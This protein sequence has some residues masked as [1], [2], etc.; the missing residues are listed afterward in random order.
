[1]TRAREIYDTASIGHDKRS[2]VNNNLYCVVR[3][4]FAGRRD[5]NARRENFAETTVARGV[6]AEADRRRVES[7]KDEKSSLNNQAVVFYCV[8][9]FF[10]FFQN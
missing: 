2:N 7:G 3:L 6:V 4:S 9:S 5:E 8:L 10:F 1:M